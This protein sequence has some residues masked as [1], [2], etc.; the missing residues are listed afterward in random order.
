MTS[1]LDGSEWHSNTWSEDPGSGPGHFNIGVDRTALGDFTYKGLIDDIRIYN[2]APDANEVYPQTGLVGHWKL[3]EQG[4]NVSI[5][6]EPSKTAIVF[7]SEA[8]LPQKWSQAA[9]A[10]YRSIERQ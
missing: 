2:R 4:A 1:Y 8:G 10:F 9:D 5:S 6:A 7:W 3:D